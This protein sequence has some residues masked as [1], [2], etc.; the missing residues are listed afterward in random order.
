[1]T[2]L[3]S[4]GGRPLL[5]GLDFREEVFVG[6]S[7]QRGCHRR[8]TLTLLGQ[9]VEVFDVLEVV[10][11]DLIDRLGHGL[12]PIGERDDAHRLGEV[13]ITCRADQHPVCLVARLEDARSEPGL[14]AIA[15]A[16][17]VH[18]GLGRFDD[19]AFR[20]AFAADPHLGQ[21]AAGPAFVD[22]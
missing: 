2:D 19:R 3:S 20:L 10:L 8:L 11:P 22:P 17:G 5:A 18:I 9:V 12:I 14:P 4:P 7:L 15:A 13:G 1:L 16:E 21:V 6:E